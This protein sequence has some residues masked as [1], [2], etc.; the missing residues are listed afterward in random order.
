MLDQALYAAEVTSS[1]LSGDGHM[2]EQDSG[3]SMY[4]SA[5]P[6]DHVTRLTDALSAARRTLQL[7]GIDAR[8]RSTFIFSFCLSEE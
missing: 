1:C 8:R 2:Y 5:C 4:S 6:V 7:S 3:V